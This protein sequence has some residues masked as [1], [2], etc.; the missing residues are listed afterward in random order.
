[1]TAGGTSSPW[2]RGVR[3]DAAKVADLSAVATLYEFDDAYTGPVCGF[4][5]ADNY[6][7]I[8]SAGRHVDHQTVG[9]DSLRHGLAA[10]Q[11][12]MRRGDVEHRR[13][14]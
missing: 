11:S 7:R 13:A 6:Y 1:M 9:E 12:L 10:N 2:S 14:N 8:N 3:D 4:G 5:S